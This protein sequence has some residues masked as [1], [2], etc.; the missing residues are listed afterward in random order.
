MNIFSCDKI[1]DKII[2]EFLKKVKDKIGLRAI[3]GITGTVSEG[4]DT[5]D[6]TATASTI[7][8]GYTAYVNGQ[9]ITGTV[10][11]QASTTITPGTSQKTA[12]ASGR[13]T[14]GNVYVAG[15]SNLT[16]SNIKSGVSI[17]GVS[18][19]MQAAGTWYDVDST[20]SS[21][22]SAEKVC[23]TLNSSFTYSR[24]KGIVL[25]A[26]AEAGQ[27]ADD[28]YI[29][30]CRLNSEVDSEG[31]ITGLGTVSGFY[32]PKSTTKTCLKNL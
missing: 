2:A 18:G 20:A 23:F 22:N 12:V 19:T 5:S 14:T 24:I 10:P 3:F 7:R 17:F 26:R 15:D 1:F 11:T 27:P 6:A 9:K 4:V 16:S 30:F 31:Y 8:S 28:S 13:I 25:F 21:Y 29:W 32:N